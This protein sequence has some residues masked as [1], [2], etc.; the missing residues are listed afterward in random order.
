MSTIRGRATQGVRQRLRSSRARVMA[1]RPD[2]RGRFGLS[3]RARRIGGWVAAL[4]IIG[5][6]AL[7]V[8]VLGGNADGTSVVPSP[9]P[10]ATMGEA[11]TI[12]FG[13]ALDPET[14]EVAVGAET[15][16]FA[17]TDRFAYSYR[18]VDPP[19]ETVWIE[20]RREADGSGETVQE[21]A[22]HRLAADALV[23]G[24]EVSAQN[25][26]DDFGAGP[27]Q[28]RI[29]LEPDSAPAATGSFEIVTTLP[30]ASP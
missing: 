13:T 22:P 18:P 19:P 15:D 14:H 26:L 12:R 23:I 8:G 30:S 3:P 4:A 24:F 28:M 7:V 10:S 20:V 6:V 25:L 1:R 5:T 21:P 11:V 17:P 9:S 2:G 16:R 29:Y 27:F